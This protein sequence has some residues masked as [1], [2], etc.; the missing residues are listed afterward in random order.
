MSRGRRRAAIFQ[1]DEDTALFSEGPGEA[2][3]PQGIEVHACSLVLH[4][5]HLLV[6]SVRGELSR[7]TR[8]VNGRLMARMKRR[9]GWGDACDQRPN[10]PNAADGNDLDADGEGDACDCDDGFMGPSELVLDCGPAC[11][12]DRDHRILAGRLRFEQVDGTDLSPAIRSDLC[13]YIVAWMHDPE[14]ESWEADSRS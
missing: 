12:V 2:V 13:T 5:T 3:V 8:Y 4:H 1:D 6:R 9:G 11:G 7:G 10:V 14:V